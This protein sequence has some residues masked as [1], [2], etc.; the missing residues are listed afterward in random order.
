[1]TH[2]SAAKQRL[3]ILGRARQALGVPSFSRTAA[4][5]LYAMAAL[6]RKSDPD[7]AADFHAVVTK[8][9]TYLG[10]R[11]HWRA[12]AQVANAGR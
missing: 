9:D 10:K 8:A 7:G 12:V 3:V 4:F 6:P 11:S 1:M 2:F 5:Y